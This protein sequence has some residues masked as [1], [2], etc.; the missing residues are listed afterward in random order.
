M[1]VVKAPKELEEMVDALTKEDILENTYITLAKAGLDRYE[2]CVRERVFDFYEVL[3]F[4]L[5]DDYWIPLTDA[6]LTSKGISLDEIWSSAK[7][8]ECSMKKVFG[9][10]TLITNDT[11]LFG[12]VGML[13]NELLRFASSVLGDYYILPSSIHEVILVPDDGFVE[14]ITLKQMVIDVNHAA[15]EEKEQL[16]DSV[17]RYDAKNGK[18]EVVA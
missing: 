3:R 11:G 18:I 14:P 12:A 7:K 16:S 17:Y 4:K 9:Q 13:D 6:F 5:T 1:N 10:M 8:P 15:V 2:R